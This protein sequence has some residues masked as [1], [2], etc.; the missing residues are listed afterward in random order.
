MSEAKHTPGEW[1]Q[2]DRRDIDQGI[3]ITDAAGEVG[4]CRVIGE[5][6]EPRDKAREVCQA[7]ANLIVAAPDLLA[8]C[9]ELKAAFMGGCGEA[10]KGSPKH[11]R[12]VKAGAA[13]DAAIAKAKG[14]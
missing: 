2:W 1:R 7:N 9:E 10:A 11:K 5:S 12:L 8:A 6:Q 3:L 13:M 4:I 14:D